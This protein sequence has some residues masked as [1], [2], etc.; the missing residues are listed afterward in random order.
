MTSCMSCHQVSGGI[1]TER[2]ES[3]PLTNEDCVVLV[4]GCNKS[5]LHWR[6]HLHGSSLDS[7]RRDASMMLRRRCHLAQFTNMRAKFNWI[8]HPW[9]ELLGND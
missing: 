6:I 9:I 3:A 2:L 7:D 1:V 5:L 4:S 8:S